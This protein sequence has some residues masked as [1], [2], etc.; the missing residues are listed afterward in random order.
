[1]TSKGLA[2]SWFDQPGLCDLF[3]IWVGCVE[4]RNLHDGGESKAAQKSGQLEA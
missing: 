4:F 2:P 3:Q 1:V